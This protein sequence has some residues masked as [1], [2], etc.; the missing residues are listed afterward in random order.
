MIPL[1]DKKNLL[2]IIERI[3]SG[4]EGYTKKINLYCIGGTALTL[5][6]K[7]YSS[8]DI[9]FLVSSEGHTAIT[10]L[11][12]E[13]G[14]KEKI[15]IDVSYDFV[16]GDSNI[17]YSLPSDFKELSQKLNSL[18]HLDLYVVCDLDIVI[19]KVLV[20]RE[21]DYEDIRELVKKIKIEDILKR[22][23]KY[24]LPPKIKEYLEN[25]LKLSFDR[26]NG[27]GEVT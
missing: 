6:E 1:I 26:I 13:I 22:F 14:N 3:D 20:G 25:K 5:T 12:A 4:L 27:S 9:D 11:A 21:K 8:V 18:E 10:S 16:V 17:S 19:T 2:R 23:Q 24:V 7:K 15:K